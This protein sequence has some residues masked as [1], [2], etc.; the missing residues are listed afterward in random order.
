[1]GERFRKFVAQWATDSG[2]YVEVGAR[3]CLCD[4]RLG[5][6]CTGLWSTNARHL[7]DGALC[8]RCHDRLR[9]L[10]YHKH[11]WMSAE[12]LTCARWKRCSDTTWQQMSAQTARELIALKEQRDQSILAA[13]GPD[14]Q[15]LFRV[16]ESFR[17]EPTAYQVGV[18]RARRMRGRAV[19][20]G[21]VDEGVFRRKDAVRIHDGDAVFHAAVIEAYRDDLVNSFQVHLS[22]RGGR[23]RLT[24][25]QTG[26]LILD[27]P[28]EISP[29][30]RVIR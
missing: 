24:D 2:R 27:W 21:P 25:G 30:A 7:A 8:R 9:E 6:F 19:V 26:W 18:L 12:Q 22:A 14:A 29:G 1:M 17:I 15:A 20:Y 3:C 13:C 23:Q 10:V 28:E 4:R 16:Q 5:F 11:E